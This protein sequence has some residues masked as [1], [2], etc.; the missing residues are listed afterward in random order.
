MTATVAPAPSELAGAEKISFTGR[1]PGAFVRELKS[2]VDKYFA[3]RK[4]SP[5][6]NWQMVTKTVVLLALTFVPYALILTNRL[7]P[8]TML[9]LCFVMGLGMAGVG[10]AV[11][12]DALHGAYS[13]NPKVN[14]IIGMSFDIMG[15]SGY[16]WRITHN[17]IHHTYTNIHGVD[18]DLDVSPLVRL[19]SG[20][21]HKP[22][23]RYQHLYA[24]LLYSFSTLFWVFVKDYKYFLAKDVGPY[25]NKKHPPG[26]VALMIATKLGHYAWTIVIP[27]VVLNVA[28]W[29]FLIGYLAMH[30]TAGLILGVVFQ[31]AHVVEGPDQINLKPDGSVEAAWMVHQFS[32]TANFATGNKLLTAYVGG[33]NY[34]VEHHLFPRVCSVH[35]PAITG[36]VREVTAKYGVP[37]YVQP[38]LW[39]A[40]RSH[41]RMLKRLGTGATTVHD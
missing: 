16:M 9:G 6:A 3:S 22:V 5:H 28:W 31:L 2:R 12:H 13:A 29:Q 39:S 8:W 24:W 15:A 38:T 30:L 20:A 17:V 34:Q 21:E 27:L 19:S 1:A 7:S 14:R 41:Y 4:L 26:E 33:L 11:S 40:V 23:H 18:E 36:I 10:F 35:Y 32:T 25:R 37:Y